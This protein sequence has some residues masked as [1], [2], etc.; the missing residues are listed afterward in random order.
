[1]NTKAYTLED[2]TAASKRWHQQIGELQSKA[3]MVDDTKKG[4]HQEIIGEL[5]QH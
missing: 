2:L 5:K 4:R 1:M 3:D